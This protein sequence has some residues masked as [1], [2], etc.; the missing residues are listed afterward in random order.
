MAVNL[1]YNYFKSSFAE[2]IPE[3]DYCF[4]RCIEDTNIDKVYVFDETKSVVETEKVKPIPT[5]KR[6]TFR[7]YFN[8]INT[9]SSASDVNA[10]INTDCYF[11]HDSSNLLNNIK[12][13]ESWCLSRWHVRSLDPFDSFPFSTNPFS[14]DGWVFRGI[15]KNIKQCDWSLGIP[16]CDSRI[17]FEIKDAGYEMRNP[18]LSLKL[19]H[20]HMSE[21][22]SY[23]AAGSGSGRIHGNYLAVGAGHI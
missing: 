6:L 5:D 1:Y 14:H 17:A 15:I 3:I 18:M 10:I 21:K 22:R 12:D 13:N 2:R 20:V 11:G 7:D 19:Y 16:G 8:F 9:K 23:D 4:N